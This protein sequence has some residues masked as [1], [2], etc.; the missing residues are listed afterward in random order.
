MTGN[1]TSARPVPDLILAAGDLAIAAY[2]AFLDRPEW[3]PATQKSYRHQIERFLSWSKDRGRTLETVKSTDRITYAEEITNRSSAQSA[4]VALTGVRGLFRHLAACCVLV[5]NPFESAKSQFRKGTDKPETSSAS[6]PAEPEPTI[7]LSE[8]K[9]ALLEIGEPDGW[10]E[11]DEDVQA[12]LVLMAEFSIGARDPAAISRFTGVP[13][14]LVEEFAERLIANGIWRPDG[15]IAAE[16]NDPQDGGL[17]FML[18]VWVA[19]GRLERAPAPDGDVAIDL[20][21]G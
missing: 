18:D 5:D 13:L 11:D 15:K 6:M 17:A 12:G 16:W 1:A 19:T 20:P 7:P 21:H 14:P 2:R 9:R 4:I 3:S 8:L 10:Q